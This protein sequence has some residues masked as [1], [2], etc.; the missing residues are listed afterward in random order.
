MSDPVIEVD[1]LVA[2][3]SQA[4]L[5]VDPGQVLVEPT[6]QLAFEEGAR[7][8]L[9]AALEDFAGWPRLLSDSEQALRH[10]VLRLMRETWLPVA[11]EHFQAGRFPTELFRELGALG[12]IGAGLVGGAAG[13]LRKRATAAIVHA[14]EYGDGGVRCALT[15]QDCVIQALV[16]F[17]SEAQ[18]ARWLEPLRLGRSI[19]S[20]ALTEPQAGSDVRALATR[21]TRRGDRWILR[22]RKGW[23][24]SAPQADVLLVWARTG[25][26]NEAIRGFL[27]ERGAAG[28][29]V[30][31]IGSAA[32]MRAAPVG[33]IVL[34][35]VSV[36]DEA[37]L[38]H[39]WGLTDIN[40]CLDYNRLTVIFGVT[41]AAR[42]C[43]EAAIDH[44]RERRQ[45]GVP[46]GSKQL[47]QARVAD[48]ARAVAVCEM[49]CLELAQRWEREPLPRFAI[50]LAKRT[51][52]ADALSVARTARGILGAGGL[53]FDNHVVRHLLNLEASS[54]YGGTD[55]IH[56]LVLG[57]LLTR[58]SA[59]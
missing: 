44:A 2:G 26:R 46:I 38:P 48:M 29:E 5:D 53:D 41:G 56:G 1:D 10:S 52:C 13:P 39:A 4:G 27:V 45:F 21:A 8:D 12:A 9:A 33:R 18:R 54:T 16:R 40:A 24:T 37:V 11:A 58:E 59:F 20:F 49:M 42:Y 3:L 30:E 32:A 36:A 15:I 55:E 28:L 14:V 25:E 34:D 6:T 47:V 51:A 22:G 57:K 35:D 23:I 19:A 43:L 7:H 31:A 17:G 50:S